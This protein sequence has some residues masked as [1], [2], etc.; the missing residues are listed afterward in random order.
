[1]MLIRTLALFTFEMDHAVV[2]RDVTAAF[3]AAAGRDEREL[4]SFAFRLLGRD[5]T[6]RDCVQEAFLKAYSAIAGG[7]R[8]ENVRPWLYRMVYYAA[9]DRLRRA[10]IEERALGRIE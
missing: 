1:M 4:V 5:D 7:T 8:P 9:I 2:P 6:A 10:S 3:E